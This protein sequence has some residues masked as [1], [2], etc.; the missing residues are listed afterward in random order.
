MS[1]ALHNDRLDDLLSFA[2]YLSWSDLV[3]QAY[4]S[5]LE[6]K[7]DAETADPVW[8]PDFAWM[9]YW[10]SSLFV[11]VEAYEAIGYTD[12]VIDALLAHPNG[13]KN[14]LRRYRNGI[15]HYQRDLLDSRLLPS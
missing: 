9:S 1:D 5:E 8:G 12:G 7:G 10:Y 14:L 4:E 15:Y 11:V 3:R 13:Y 6:K 2:R